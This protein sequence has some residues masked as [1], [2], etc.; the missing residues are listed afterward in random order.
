[1]SITA[2][3]RRYRI[4]ILTILILFSF[5][6]QASAYTFLILAFGDSITQGYKRTSDGT[7]Y[8]ITSPPNGARTSDGYEPELENDFATQSNHTAYVYNWGYGGE[9]TYQG[10]NRI[11]SVLTSRDADFIL[12]MEGANDLYAGVSASATKANLG[13]MI[14][15]SLARQTEPIIATVTPNTAPNQPEGYKIPTEYNPAIKYLASEKGITMADQYAA[16]VGN[17]SSYNSG[18]GLHLNDS[19]E[20]VM[21]QRWYNAILDH[22]LPRPFAIAPI[23]NLLLNP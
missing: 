9:R 21:A 4:A 11:D 15:K 2:T 3:S 12:I 16:L 23:I 19:G 10:V 13:I 22:G 17:W 20:R 6:A 8:G 18:D 1:M 14:D 7:I 5:A